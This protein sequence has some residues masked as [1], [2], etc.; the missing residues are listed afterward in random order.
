MGSFFAVLG[1][2]AGFRMVRDTPRVGEVGGEADTGP[3][4]CLW[5]VQMAL[6]P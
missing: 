3:E 2:G 4:G 1:C 5:R 6:N